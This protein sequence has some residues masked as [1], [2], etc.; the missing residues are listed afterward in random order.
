MVKAQATMNDHQHWFLDQCA[1]A[2]GQPFTIY[3][4]EMF[5]TVKRG[6]HMNFR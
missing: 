2:R 6:M 5:R 1:G 3:I 4:K